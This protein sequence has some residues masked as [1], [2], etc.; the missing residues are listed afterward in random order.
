MKTTIISIE[1][2]IATEGGWGKGRNKFYIQIRRDER[3]EIKAYG[4]YDFT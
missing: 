4:W 3:D 2:V 1:N